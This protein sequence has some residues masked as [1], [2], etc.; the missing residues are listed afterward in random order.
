MTR[1]GLLLA[2][3]ACLTGCVQSRSRT[4]VPV[5]ATPSHSPSA[6]SD[7]RSDATA[8]T[9]P[10]DE[11]DS[12]V[13]LASATDASVAL[14]SATLDELEESETLEASPMWNAP[15]PSPVAEAPPA[16]GISLEA[17]IASVYETY[18][19]LEAALS[20]RTI[21]D[22][23]QLAAAGEFDLKFKAASENG[24]MGFYQ[25]YRQ[26]VGL[27]QPTYNGGE[28]FAGYRIG[29]GDFEPWY[30]E[31]QTNDGGEF[32]A[33]IAVPFSRNR[34][35]DSRRAEL[36]RATYGRQLVEPDI[37][38]QLIDFVQEASYAYWDWVAA[39]ARFQI[40]EQIL[41][42]AEERT[43][44]IQQQVEGGFLDPPEL[45]DNLRLVAERRG[46]R[47][48]AARKLQ[49][50]AVKLSLY[51]RASDGQ[52][53]IPDP[54]ALPEFPEPTPISPE[55]VSIDTHLAWQQRPELALLDLYQRQLEVD[56]AEAH[57]E[58][59]PAVDAVMSGSQDV[60]LPSSKK[61]DK[62]P[63]VLDASIFVDVPLQRRKARGKLQAVEGKIAQ[64][65]AKR[66]L[67]ED[68]I[69]ADVQAAYAGLM[70]AYEQLQQT[71]QAMEFA[72]DL[73]RRERENFEAGFSDLL[74]VTL[75]EQY[76]RESAEKVVDALQMYYQAR[77]DY[78]AG[79]R[80]GSPAL[81]HA[82]AGCGSRTELRLRDELAPVRVSAI[83][84]DAIASDRHAIVRLGH[85][86]CCQLDGLQYPQTVVISS[87]G[88]KRVSAD[89]VNYHHLLYFWA[90]A[91]EG[92][93]AAACEKLHLAQPTISGQLRKLER[94]VGGKLYDRVGRELVL[95]D[96]GQTVYKYADEI[97]S[98]GQE[99]EEVLK[100]RTTGRP[101][102]LHVGVPQVL[103][104]LIA[105]R[106]LEPALRLPEPVQ[107]VCREGS[108]EELLT[109]LARHELDVVFSDAPAG[110]FVRV[111][112]FNHPL[113]ECGIGIFGTQRLL[114]QFGQGPPDS[115]MNAPF[116]MPALGTALR[117]S[118]DHWL[119]QAGLAIQLVGEFDDTALMKVFA[120][121]NVGFVPA[122]IAIERE[123]R[124]QFALH[125]V[126]LVPDAKEQFYAITVE[127]KLRHPAVV[128]ISE[129]AR[130]ELFGESE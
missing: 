98:V 44:R 87:C 108:Q 10:E 24:P 127:R 86:T 63:F 49:Q 5:A 19:L 58:F 105:Y 128:A 102:R 116:L 3:I 25:T 129:A 123:I 115:L 46:K 50:T 45:T 15:L 74:K 126:C 62:G 83:P 36:W 41:M 18:P 2:L 31:R 17:V 1:Y 35:I 109:M 14:A 26:S 23:L 7:S 6:R 28:V 130:Q 77:A 52:P 113:G 33:G 59:R 32:K 56:Y 81:G 69:M 47:A 30:L 117:Q 54:L 9:L 96:L 16:G 78:R 89:W 66:Q 21:A 101:V 72:E 119:L 114:E 43:E 48:D 121:A 76:A 94:Q 90:V 4:N 107:L 40:A 39:G 68:K 42:L 38:A 122:P 13:R 110:G 75:R 11:S 12:P 99:L 64:L 29:R 67:T 112:A 82:D 65:H 53:L 125:L 57:N 60:G 37:H 27:V 84:H 73:A 55:D 103:P 20:S 91:R 111:R 120:E 79:A 92:S 80:L 118:V 88:E 71:R 95:T 61:N 51:Y 8:G 34:H 106:L 85:V 93:I 97:F 22:G 100:G 70:A 124:D 104:K